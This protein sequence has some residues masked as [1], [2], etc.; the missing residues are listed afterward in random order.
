VFDQ[1]RVQFHVTMRA[2]AEEYCD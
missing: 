2:T 1:I